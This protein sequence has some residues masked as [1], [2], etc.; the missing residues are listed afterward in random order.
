MVD[1]RVRAEPGS[2]PSA[3]LAHEPR[4]IEDEDGAACAAMQSAVRSRAFS[5]GPLAREHELSITRFQENVLA[6]M[7]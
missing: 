1:M 7:A 3:M 2:D 5:V 6:A 4:I